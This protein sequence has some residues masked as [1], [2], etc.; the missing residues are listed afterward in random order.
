MLCPSPVS[1][2]EKW[3][4]KAQSGKRESRKQKAE[5][6]VLDPCSVVRRLSSIHQAQGCVDARPYESVCAS[7][8]PVQGAGHAFPADACRLRSYVSN[9]CGCGSVVAFPG[10]NVFG[11]GTIVIFQGRNALDTGMVVAF[12]GRNVLGA[13]TIVAFPSRNVFGARMLIRGI[14]R[15]IASVGDA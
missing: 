13:G 1:A 10:W 12:P 14:G 3:G 9:V 2:R 5:Q 8:Q 7:F 11:G 4:G 15:G 6:V